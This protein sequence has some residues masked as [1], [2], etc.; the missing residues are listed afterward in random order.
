MSRKRIPLP[1]PVRIVHARPRLFAAIIIGAALVPFLPGGWTLSTRLLA[2]WDVG[3]MLYLGLTYYLVASETVAQIKQ[4]AA[5]E[6]EGRLAILILSVAASAASLFAIVVQL[7]A[8]GAQGPHPGALI[9]AICTIVLS[10]FFVH[11]I[12]AIH[13]A[14]EFYGDHAGKGSGLDFPGNEKPDHWDFV[15]FSFVIGMTSQVSDVAVAHKA[16]RR[17]VLAHGILSFFF[18]I[19]LLALTFNIAASAIGES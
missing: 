5:Q 16:A 12:F 18:N 11:S 14:H 10:W 7:G 17:M 13:Y 2:G 15:Y 4:R 1:Y 9:F 3:V 19:A 8:A 6:D